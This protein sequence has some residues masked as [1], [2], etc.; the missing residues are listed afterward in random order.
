MRDLMRSCASIRSGGHRKEVPDGRAA[1][2]SG[3]GKRALDPVWVI[4]LLACCVAAPARAQQDP[5]PPPPP[6]EAAGSFTQF[7]QGNVTGGLDTGWEYGGKVELELTFDTQGLGLWPGGSLLAKMATRYEDSASRLSGAAL[8]VN[9]ALVDPARDGTVAAIGSLNFTQMMPIGAGPADLLVA[10]FGRFQTLDLV[11]EPFLGGSGLTRWMNLAQNA[12]PHEGR[13]IPIVTLGVTTALV[14]RGEPVATFAIFDP[15]PSSTT[16]GLSD[17]FERGVTL[18]PGVTI[19]TRFFGRTGHHGLR[20]SWSSQD[21]TP[22]DEI[23]QLLLPPD[24]R[25]IETESGSWSF[26]Y[27]ANQFLSES[28]VGAE[29]TGWGLFW[30]LG[31]ADQATNPVTMFANTGIGGASPIAGRPLDDFGVGFAYTWF[32]DDLKEV[33]NLIAPVRD[34]YNLEAYYRVA[35]ASWL[36]LTGDLQVIRP[37]RG[38]VDTA[39]VPGARLQV[40]F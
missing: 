35:L 33:L 20:G 11:T 3:A 27:S 12:P 21:V 5:P 29:H 14:L 7:Y 9:T 15:T 2:G 38:L 31:F 1:D 17:L 28:G 30:Q 24:E 26:T 39:V 8:P 25:D 6:L 40:V 23:P 4:G 18:A 34:E 32:S 37:F 36:L 19:P 13:N 22:F 16:S 10:S